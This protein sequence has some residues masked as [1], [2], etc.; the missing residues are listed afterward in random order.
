MSYGKSFSSVG[1][2][3]QVRNCQNEKGEKG[4][5]GGEGVGEAEEGEGVIF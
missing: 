5:E 4:G 1:A 3:L 2:Q